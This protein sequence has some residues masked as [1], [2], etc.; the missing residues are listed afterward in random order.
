MH[1]KLF[2]RI[3]VVACIIVMGSLA[4]LGGLTL[5]FSDD[6]WEG[7]VK[8]I[9]SHSWTISDDVSISI[10]DYD[11]KTENVSVKFTGCASS[12]NGDVTVQCYRTDDLGR[13]LQVDEVGE[14]ST[15]ANQ[16]PITVEAGGIFTT[17]DIYLTDGENRFLF[18]ATDANDLSALEVVTIV[19]DMGKVE[20]IDMDHLA[21]TEDGIMYQDNIIVLTFVPGTTSDRSREIIAEIGGT[22]VGNIAVLRRYQVKVTVASYED[23][24]ALCETYKQ[25]YSEISLA[26]PELVTEYSMTEDAS[27]TEMYTPND[28][29]STSDAPSDWDESLPSGNN[30]GLECIQAQ[31]AWQFTPYFRNVTVGVID[32]GFLDG[33]DDLRLY[34]GDERRVI[35]DHGTHIAGTIAALHDNRTGVSGVMNKGR[36]FAYPLNATP[37]EDGEG[38]YMNSSEYMYSLVS[39]VT[40]GSSVINVSLGS[41]SSEIHNE[42]LMSYAAIMGETMCVLL[43]EGYDFVVVQ[44]AGNGDEYGNAIDAINSGWYI[45]VKALTLEPELYEVASAL[46]STYGIPVQELCDRVIV[47]A[48]AVNCTVDTPYFELANSSNCGYYVD[49]AAPGTSIY[50]TVSGGMLSMGTYGYMTGTSMAAPHVAAVAAMAWST[51]PEITGADIKE[52]LLENTR[53]TA[54]S[55]ADSPMPGYTY[56]IVNAYLAV[57]AAIDFERVETYAEITIKDAATGNPL[58]GTSI[59]ITRGVEAGGPSVGTFVTD[60]QGVVNIELESGDYLLN[61]SKD[62]YIADSYNMTLQPDVVNKATYALSR[63]LGEN[64]FRIVLTWGQ[65][66]NDLDSHLLGY[67]PGSDSNFRV[68]WRNQVAGSF[69]NLDV[70]DTSSFGP[71]TITITGLPDRPLLYCVHDY[72]NRNNG[73]SMAMSGSS[74][75]VK[76]MRHTE[77]IA[78]FTVSPNRQSVEWVVFWLMPD[79]SIVPVDAYSS[80]SVDS[81]NVGTSTFRNGVQ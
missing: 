47:V 58:P 69:V 40:N 70:D 2:S 5:R 13:A 39:C 21:T 18:V 14:T 19:Y 9:A 60:D 36:L 59:T 50:S 24:T 32:G 81:G 11:T 52:I 74:A 35:D 3:L 16:Y 33:H 53:Y 27:G 62:G 72:T 54:S 63:Q 80:G 41:A 68:F 57:K 49:I 6:A 78:T 22:E 71:E 31:S 4:F 42:V 15:L 43:N 75:N 34:F 45:A 65:T 73:R 20:G 17:P 61:C 7:M 48:N 76:V 55:A 38:Y 64:E 51:N 46:T 23:L 29:W 12:V 26:Y 8:A 28:P 25:T 79:G 67:T 66:P 56:D 1:S 10:D 77:T 44:A 37:T 30:W